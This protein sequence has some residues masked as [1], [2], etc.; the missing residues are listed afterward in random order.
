ME[1]GVSTKYIDMLCILW[2]PLQEEFK[3]TNINNVGETVVADRQ[4]KYKQIHKQKS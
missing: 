3:R 1:G 4:C 2:T